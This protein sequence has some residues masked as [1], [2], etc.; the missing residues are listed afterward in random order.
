MGTVM[1]RPRRR[2]LL[3]IRYRVGVR[4][5]SRTSVGSSSTII[6]GVEV[7]TRGGGTT[8]RSIYE[9]RWAQNSS[10]AGTGI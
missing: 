1:G 6:V 9:G 5:S 8:G 3:G 4:R 10:G 2:E 7:R